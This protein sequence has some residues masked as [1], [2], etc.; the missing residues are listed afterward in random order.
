VTSD[1]QAAPA[2]IPPAFCYQEEPMETTDTPPLPDALLDRLA[3]VGGACMSSV[4]SQ[5]GSYEILTPATAT[6]KYIWCSAAGL[7]GLLDEWEEIGGYHP[8]LAL[9]FMEAAREARELDAHA[10]AMQN[11]IG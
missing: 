5:W 4:P 2:E 10:P 11:E 3:A 9:I 6:Y 8:R 7:A 1:K